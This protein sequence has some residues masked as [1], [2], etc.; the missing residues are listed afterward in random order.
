[1]AQRKGCPVFRPDREC[2]DPVDKEMGDGLCTEHAYEWRKSK[3]FHEAAKDDGV[4]FLM[5]LGARKSAMKEVNKFKRRWVKRVNKES[6]PDNQ[7]EEE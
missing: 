2:E 5:G 3:E 1:M 7:Q 6:D 4:R